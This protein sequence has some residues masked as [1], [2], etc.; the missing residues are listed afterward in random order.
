[1]SVLLQISWRMWQWKHF[2]NRSV[3]FWR[4]Y[5]YSMGGY[6]LAHPV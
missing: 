2:E 1:M 3:F 5:V 6:F 4:T